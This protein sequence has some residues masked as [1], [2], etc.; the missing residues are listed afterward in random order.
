ML[1]E[2]IA[3]TMS[4]TNALNALD[5]PYAIGVPSPAQFTA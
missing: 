2:P 3:A 1:A 4:V 5:V